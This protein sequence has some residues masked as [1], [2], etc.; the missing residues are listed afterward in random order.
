RGVRGNAIV[1][2]DEAAQCIAQAVE[3]A[4]SV[5]GAS[6]GGVTVATSGGQIASLR[7]RTQISLGGKPISDN[8]LMRANQAALAQVKM[9]ERRK[10]L[11]GS[12]IASANED[13]EMIE[14]PPRGD[15]PGAGPVTAPRS[16]LKGI[17]QPRVEE[18]LELLRDRLKSSGAPI[19]PDASIILT[20]G[21]SQ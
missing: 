2:V 18:T 9:G 7:V 15:D 1:N 19:E 17:I 13:R 4:E 21:A 16:L 12:A 10:T 11:H 3:R 8:D 14:A 6:V 5:A 20:G